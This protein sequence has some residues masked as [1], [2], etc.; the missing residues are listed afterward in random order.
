V[1]SGRYTATQLALL[2]PNQ[3]TS[4]DQRWRQFVR[5]KVM[6]SDAAPIAFISS[7]TKD[8]QHADTSHSPMWRLRR[9][10]Y[11]LNSDD[12]FKKRLHPNHALRLFAWVSEHVGDAGPVPGNSLPHVDYLLKILRASDLYICILGDQRQDYP[13]HG[14]LLEWEYLPTEV[15]YLEIELYAAVMY[16]KKT[17]FFV[18]D[19]FKPGP[20]LKSLLNLLSWAMPDWRNLTPLPAELIRS[21]VQRIIEDHTLKQLEP[22]LTQISLVQA[23]YRERSGLTR[24][25][26]RKKQLLFL[27]RAHELRPL[28]D[29]QRVEALIRG[30][31]SVPN[32]E[33]RMCRLWLAVRELMPVRYWSDEARPAERELF[34]YWDCV[35]ADWASAA[36]WHGW[37]GHLYAGTVAPLNSQWVLRR[38]GLKPIREFQP[39]VTLPPEGGLA[40]AYYS[41]AGFMSGVQYWRCLHQAGEF[42]KQAINDRSGPPDNLLAIRGSIRLAMGLWPLAVTDFREMLRLRER[43]DAPAIKIADALMH[44]GYAY[45]LI[46]MWGKG[47]TLLNDA[48]RMLEQHPDDPNLPRARRKLASA[49]KR[50]LMFD[51]ADALSR[52]AEQDEVRLSL[53]HR[54]G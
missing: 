14:T 10:I 52:L 43:Q 29:K 24:R 3:C 33:Q 27:D 7:F 44:L 51:E 35:L 49:C 25:N 21:S 37:Q 8:A 41:I 19:G 47:R 1:Q 31:R 53:P 6:N 32:Y 23:F 4:G 42:V 39:S 20:R 30:Y 46:P 28:P 40:S 15:S 12:A 17:H 18:L 16:S 54:I 2:D 26:S 13:D 5:T 22:N 36:S 11:E 38:I 9:S 50:C 48:V 34:P 45:S